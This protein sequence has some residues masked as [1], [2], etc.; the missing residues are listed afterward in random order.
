M[1]FVHRMPDGASASPTEDPCPFADQIYSAIQETPELGALREV[2]ENITG[3][4]NVLSGV[5]FGVLYR[6]SAESS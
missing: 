5:V 2:L 3:P 1:R 4:S 6:G